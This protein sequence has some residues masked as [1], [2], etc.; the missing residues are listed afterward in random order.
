MKDSHSAKLEGR[1]QIFVKLS[2]RELCGS[3]ISGLHHFD[4]MSIIHCVNLE[5]KVGYEFM[6][7]QSL[8]YFL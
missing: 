3:K 6:R 2:F 4:N 1:P 7:H 8:K 5:T